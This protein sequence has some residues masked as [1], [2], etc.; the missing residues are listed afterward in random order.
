MKNNNNEDE[1]K[2]KNKRTIKQLSMR[3]KNAKLNK[4]RKKGIWKYKYRKKNG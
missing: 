1:K 4:G 3:H 2:F